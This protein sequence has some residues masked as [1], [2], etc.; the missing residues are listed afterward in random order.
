MNDSKLTKSA[1]VLDVIIK[2]AT[3]LV[4]CAAIVLILLAVITFFGFSHF[5]NQG[6]YFIQFEGLKIYLAD[7]S[8]LSA[9]YL[10]AFVI[11]A[12][13]TAIVLCVA[14]GFV[15][16]FSRQIL[17]PMKEG[18]PFTPATTASVRNIAWTVLIGGAIRECLGLV[19]TY[20]LQKASPIDTILTS[21]A[22]K[23]YEITYQFH[24]AF[25]IV[26]FLILF[27]SYIF[28]YGQKLQQES[29]ETL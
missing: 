7:S 17:A 18:R 26:F 16:R 2:I 24:F 14:I 20:L 9:S 28:S 10:K 29:D 13:A 15:F 12:M 5:M 23:S 25:I 11:T 6:D 22:V 19:E 21:G 4:G 3:I 8:A 27:L 1:R